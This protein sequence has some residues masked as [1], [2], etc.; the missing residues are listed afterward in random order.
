MR[1]LNVCQ[2]EYISQLVELSDCEVSHENNLY[3][4]TPIIQE[5]MGSFDATEVRRRALL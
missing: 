4:N 5:S 1:L 3:L 2:S